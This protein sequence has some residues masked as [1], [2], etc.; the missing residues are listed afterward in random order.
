M[1]DLHSLLDLHSI[2]TIFPYQFTGD[3][4]IYDCTEN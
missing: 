3:M 1:L 2:V 4:I